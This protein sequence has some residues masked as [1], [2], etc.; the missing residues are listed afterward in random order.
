MNY[1]SGKIITIFAALLLAVVAFTPITAKKAPVENEFAAILPQEPAL[2]AHAYSIK[3]IG[4]KKP[5]AKRR[6]W[7]RLAPASLTKLMT[8]V[9]ASEIIRADSPIVFSEEVKKAEPKSSDAGVGEK[10]WRDDAIRFALIESANDAALALAETVGQDIFIAK[11][12]EKAR[13]L[14]LQNSNFENPT[15]L[16]EAQHLSTAEDLALLAEYITDTHQ[17]L[18]E[19]TRIIETEIFSADGRA[20]KAKNTNELLQEFPAITGGKTGFT[21]NAK[22][23][24]IFLYPVRPGKTAVIV[25]LGSSDRFGDGRK[26]IKWL[27]TISWNPS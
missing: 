24:L 21:D 22:G 14:G 18:W 26:I 9:I 16:D 10:F 15:G 6:E 12:N 23:A 5:L 19:I 13:A 3:I 1:E 8:A 27:E 17:E 20:H 2:D 4:E 25:L 11:M 7:K